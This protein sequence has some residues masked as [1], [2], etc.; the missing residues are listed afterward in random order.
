MLAQ[1]SVVTDQVVKR[2]DSYSAGDVLVMRRVLVGSVCMYVGNTRTFESL[3]VESSFLV[4]GYIFRGYWSSSCMKV[5]G[6]RSRS[7]EQKKREIPCSA[8]HVKLRWAI[9]PVLWK[10]EPRSLRAAWGLRLWWIE[11][12]DRHLCHVIGSDHA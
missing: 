3:D 6:S 8:I 11:W 2:N 4:C 7:Q 10:I 9:S 12:C 1:S 5:I